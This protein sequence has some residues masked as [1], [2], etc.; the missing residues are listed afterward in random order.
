MQDVI[1][2]RSVMIFLG[3]FGRGPSVLCVLA[4]RLFLRLFFGNRGSRR[5]MLTGV[6]VGVTTDHRPADCRRTPYPVS[7][8][9]P[10]NRRTLPSLSLQ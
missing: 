10:N 1:H 2:V 3:G 9:Q 6:P 7:E 5:K 4:I 8:E